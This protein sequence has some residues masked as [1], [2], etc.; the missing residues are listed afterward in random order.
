MW[1]AVLDALG[2]RV[3]MAVPDTVVVMNVSV[4]QT[5]QDGHEND[6]P[7]P[8]TFG[9]RSDELVEAEHVNAPRRLAHGFRIRRAAF[10]AISGRRVS[11]I[12]YTASCA[13]HTSSARIRATMT[14]FTIVA[15]ASQ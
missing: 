3:K 11:Q 10:P 1:M 7:G 9:D 12:A 8:G 15:P 4:E 6:D 5:A 14:P 13:C 2:M